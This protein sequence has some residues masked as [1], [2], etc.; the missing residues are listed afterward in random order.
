MAGP[1]SQSEEWTLQSFA[2]RWLGGMIGPCDDGLV[3][4]IPSVLQ[5]RSSVAPE[6]RHEWKHVV[7]GEAEKIGTQKIAARQRFETIAPVVDGN[8][9]PQLK[10]R[11]HAGMIVAVGLC[12]E[13]RGHH[14][15]AHGAA[16]DA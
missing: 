5:D 11:L 9:P 7:E 13:C 15:G 16:R 2:T 6:W 10:W 8:A 1:R 4:I 14:D 12:V 3:A